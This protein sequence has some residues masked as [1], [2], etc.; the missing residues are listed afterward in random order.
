MISRKY[1]GAAKRN[2]DGFLRKKNV[3]GVGAGLCNKKDRKPGEK[4]IIV[5]VRKKE[6]KEKL[7]EQD[8]LPE[9]VTAGS[10]DVR[11]EVIEVGDIRVLTAEHRF[12]H[13]P[14]VSGISCGHFS[15]TAGT[16]G[17][18]VEKDG[19]PYVLSNNHV[20]ANSNMAQIGDPIYQPGPIDGGRSRHTVARLSEFV[21]ISFT[22]DNKVDAAL[23]LV[24]GHDQDVPAD[25]PE[26]TPEPKKEGFL[27][28]LWAAIV[29]FF[30]K[31][32]G[33]T[34]TKQSTTVIIDGKVIDGDTTPTPQTVEF[35]NTVLNMPTP[36]TYQLGDAVEGSLIQK[37]G[38]TTGY[39]STEVLVLGATVEVEFGQGQVARFIDQIVTGNFSDGGDSGSVVFDMAG[40]AVGL[41]FAGS[42]AVTILNP[43]KTV[44]AELGIDRIWR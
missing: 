23:A 2:A 35:S 31:L 28:R 32:F 11:I 3:V 22:A 41:L 19:K 17:L 38:R 37:S 18:F 8:L 26:A 6:A 33:R 34:V 10:E 21:P 9:T 13:R 39:T 16:L 5:L 25:P 4:A 36:I 24:E 14:L 44:F 27:A 15:I 30:R 29:S 20:L 42:D 1:I 7:S 43:I 12:N 40:N